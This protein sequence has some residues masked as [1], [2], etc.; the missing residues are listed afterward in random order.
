MFFEVVWVQFLYWIV[1]VEWGVWEFVWDFG[2]CYGVGVG[3]D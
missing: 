3:V 1:V 2:D